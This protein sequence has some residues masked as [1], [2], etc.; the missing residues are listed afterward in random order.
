[1]SLSEFDKENYEVYEENFLDLYTF[2]KRFNKI[3]I[4]VSFR[5]KTM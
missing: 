3:C 5:K 1:M 4:S 2:F